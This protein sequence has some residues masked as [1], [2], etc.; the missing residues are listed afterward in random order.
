M[1]AQQLIDELED[2][3]QHNDNGLFVES[4]EYLSEISWREL[5]KVSSQ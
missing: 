1:T 2:Y 5:K 3:P 4:Q